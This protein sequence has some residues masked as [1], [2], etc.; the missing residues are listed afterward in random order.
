MKT[1]LQGSHQLRNSTA[2]DLPAHG[3]N[4]SSNPQAGNGTAAGTGTGLALGGPPS[5]GTN[6][7]LNS[8]QGSIA[9]PTGSGWAP[10]VSGQGMGNGAPPATP[11][12][13]GIATASSP[14]SDS[15]AGAAPPSTLLTITT[16]G[17][18]GESGSQS[19]P[20]PGVT[21]VNTGLVGASQAASTPGSDN[22]G[23]SVTT[24]SLA[25]QT[26]PPGQTVD[27]Q[28]IPDSGGPMESTPPV[29]QTTGANGATGGD[30][31]T[32]TTAGGGTDPGQSAAASTC[33][34][35]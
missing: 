29:A 7:A 15:L 2:H 6:G 24:P 16:P 18:P 12:T 30:G 10:T 3:M 26:A 22:P 17:S 5:N 8:P 34:C 21:P 28:E 13:T 14:G 27:G 9:T 11:T 31:P 19:G 25:S 23:A 32:V 33:R 20:P 1:F 4:S 35:N